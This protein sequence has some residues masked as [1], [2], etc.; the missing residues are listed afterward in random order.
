VDRIPNDFY[1]DH[2]GHGGFRDDQVADEV[3]NWLAENPADIILLH[4]GTNS[5]EES[6]A[7]VEVILNEIDSFEANNSVTI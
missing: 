1:K 6:A 4:I 7:D 5:V 2:E 3:Y